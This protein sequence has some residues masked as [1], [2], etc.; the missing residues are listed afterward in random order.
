M[1]N[2]DCREGRN[3]HLLRSLRKFCSEHSLEVNRVL[4]LWTPTRNNVTDIVGTPIVFA[5]LS[6]SPRII[7]E[8]LPFLA[9]R[10]QGRPTLLGSPLLRLQIRISASM[11]MWCPFIHFTAAEKFRE[12]VNV[13]YFRQRTGDT[14]VNADFEHRGVVKNS[15]TEKAIIHYRLLAARRRMSERLMDTVGAMRCLR[16]V[17]S[18]V[19]G[20]KQCR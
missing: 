9:A 3:A 4:P 14:D 1:G 15:S 7:L 6:D 16:V 20:S 8:M 13:R 2:V 19:D 10:A 12:E 5:F 17:C 11:S 18:R